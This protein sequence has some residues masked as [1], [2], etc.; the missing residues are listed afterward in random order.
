MRLSFIGIVLLNASLALSECCPRYQV[1]DFHM[2]NKHHIC[3]HGAPPPEG[4]YCGL[5]SCNIFGCNCSGGCLRGTEQSCMQ[6]CT[7]LG[8]KLFWS[9][10]NVCD[11]YGF[12]EA[13]RGIFPK[14]ITKGKT[15][16]EVL[17]MTTKCYVNQNFPGTNFRL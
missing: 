4:Y 9:C 5:G 3:L 2:R 1:S 16:Y 11:V 10:L 15:H 17:Q 6:R 7:S 12:Y 13:H 14:H 8:P